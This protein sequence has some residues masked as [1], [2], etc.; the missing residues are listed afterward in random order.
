[1]PQ[2]RIRVWFRKGE[3]VRYI[4]HLDVLRYWERCLRRAELP[5]AY[6]QGFTPHPRL[7]FAGPLP[8]GYLGENEIVD[9]TLDGRVTPAEFE[10]RLAAQTSPDLALTAAQEVALAAVSPQASMR[11]A[12]YRV[13]VRGLDRGAVGP[14]IDAFLA[15]STF[16]WTEER[17]ERERTFDLRTAIADLRL[18]PAGDDDSAAVL[19]MRL[20]AAAD[21]MVRPETV[22]AALFP[23]A[24]IDTIARVGILFDDPS[25]ARLAWRRQGRF[26]A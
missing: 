19:A 10:Q 26:E 1:M 8:L 3:R 25:P 18:A 17:R 20:Q 11:W 13:T 14:A 24:T 22:M 6:S 16:P 4:S 23:A 12:D 21:L 15:Q 7:Q 9:V 2:Q 5:L